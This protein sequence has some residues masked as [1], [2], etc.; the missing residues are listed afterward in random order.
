MAYDN[1]LAVGL[2]VG[3]PSAVI[4]LFCLIMWYRNERKQSRED[5]M[6]NEIDLGLRDDQLFSQFEEE[7][8]KKPGE[9]NKS[10]LTQEEAGA[11]AHAE[12]TYQTSLSNGS[13]S[14][15]NFLDRKVIATHQKTPSSYDF[16]ESVIPIL[17]PNA[18]PNA[19]TQSPASSNNNVPTT[20]KMANGS[21][22]SQPHIPNDNFTGSNDSIVVSPTT[23]SNGPDKSL[24]TLAKQLT[25]PSYFEKLPSRAATVNFKQRNQ[26]TSNNSSSDILTNSFPSTKNSQA[27]DSASE[28][29]LG[30]YSKV[31]KSSTHS[32]LADIANG[33]RVDSADEID[34]SFEDM[35]E[36]SGIS[37]LSIRKNDS[38]EAYKPDVVFE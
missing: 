35:N 24:D 33:N 36:H 31:P 25:G 3:I 30:F 5:R 21:T 14:T 22:V 2:G 20:N 17:P 13:S 28:T 12:K 10:S 29:Q 7:L 1:S 32:N 23:A 6:E 34:E 18:Y 37:P 26:I 4:I 16:Y 19:S 9:R 8:H 38:Q 15:T 27:Q 11:E